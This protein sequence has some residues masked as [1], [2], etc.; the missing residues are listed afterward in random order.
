MTVYGADEVE[1]GLDSR[2]LP[3]A[4]VR[5][6]AEE[7]AEHLVGD[8]ERLITVEDRG[9]PVEIPRVAL[10]PFTIRV[11]EDVDVKEHHRQ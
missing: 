6:D 7:R 10:S 9:Q 5:D 4:P 11:D 8:A 3:E 1:R 2:R